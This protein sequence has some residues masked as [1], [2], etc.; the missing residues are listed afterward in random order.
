MLIERD[1]KKIVPKGKTVLK[2]NDEVLIG[3]TFVKAQNDIKLNETYIDKNHEWINKKINTITFPQNFLIAL[4]KRETESF[5]P[6]GKSEIKE[7]D[8]IVFYEI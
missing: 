5:V 1:G 4:I 2:E 8:T 6:H 3:T 7:G